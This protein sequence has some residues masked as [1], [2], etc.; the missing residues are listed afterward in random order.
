MTYLI[1]V[2]LDPFVTPLVKK[3]IPGWGGRVSDLS[4]AFPLAVF[5]GIGAVR[6]LIVPY[7]FDEEREETIKGL[8]QRLGNI[9]IRKE[10]CDEVAKRIDKGERIRDRYAKPSGPSTEEAQEWLD[11]FESYIQA[12][13]PYFLTQ[14][15]RKTEISPPDLS[16]GN[17]REE[18]QM[19]Q[20]LHL[21]LEQSYKL[22]DK[23][24]ELSVSHE[25]SSTSP[26][27]R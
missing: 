24:I 22:L 10:H 2:F 26:S 20:T 17:N 25:T 18:R 15:R 23:L 4:W 3:K 6:F 11:D 7:W 5:L 1:P 21:R 13:G 27:M 14:W 12:L 19:Y 8:N 16:R 9:A